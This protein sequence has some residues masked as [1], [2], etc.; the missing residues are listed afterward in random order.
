MARGCAKASRMAGSESHPPSDLG[1]DLGGLHQMP[2]DGLAFTIRVGREVD[3]LRPMCQPL[4]LLH[5]LFLLVR[6]AVLGL[7]VVVHIDG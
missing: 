4:E 2:G 1:V 7:E 3:L 6:H 5:D